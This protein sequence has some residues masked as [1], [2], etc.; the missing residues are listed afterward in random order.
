MAVHLI[1]FLIDTGAALS[2]LTQRTGN[3]SNHKKYIMG[4][5]GK[6]L[7]TLSWSPERSE[8]TFYC[9]GNLQMNHWKEYGQIDTKIMHKIGRPSTDVYKGK[10]I[11]NP[12]IGETS[13][14]GGRDMDPE[15]RK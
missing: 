1:E 9:R 14:K 6:N 15:I 3:L 8:L 7:G 2:V 4:L 5:S 10:I 12:L 11:K 13:C